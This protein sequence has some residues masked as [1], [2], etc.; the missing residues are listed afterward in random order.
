MKNS[1]STPLFSQYATQTSEQIFSALNTSLAGLSTQ[2]VHTRQ[3]EVGLNQIE[4]HSVSWHT[5]LR[6][7]FTSP[8]IYVF[9]I[10][11]AIYL[12]LGEYTNTIIV[13]SII[14]VNAILGFYQEYHAEAN[15][16]LLKQYLISSVTACRDGQENKVLNNL[17]VPGDI[18]I[19]YPGD[20]VPAD[21]RF[22]QAENLMVDESTLTGESS[23]VTKTAA[24][25]EQSP[26]NPFEADNIGFAGTTISSGKAIAV[27]FA[28]GANTTLGHIAYLTTETMS[29]S[30]LNKGTMRLA[31]F[32]FSLI[33]ITL[34]V[35]IVLNI[36]LKG[37]ELP[38]SELFIFSIALAITAIPEALPIVITFCLSKGASLL[39]QQKVIV[40]RLSAIEDLGSIEVLCTDK[41]GTLTENT[42][43]VVDTFS[44]NPRDTLFYAANM[45]TEQ[46]KKNGQLKGFD[47][48]LWQSLTPEEQQK[49]LAF[50][51]IKEIPFDPV[52]KKNIT[53]L[54]K[55][56]LSY[57]LARGSAEEIIKHITLT[58]E[59]VTHIQ[60]W[61]IDE[62]E[63]KGNRVIAIAKKESPSNT[64]SDNLVN[65]LHDL[66]FLGLI[67][68]ADPIKKTALIAV[69]KA[70]DLGL[71][72]KVLSGDSP[73]VCASVA[74]QLGLITTKDEVITGAEFEKKSPKERSHCAH[75]YT[76]FARVTPEQKYEIITYLQK[77]YSVGYLGDGINDA[78]ALKAA[79]VSMVVQDAAPI[80]R[81]TA[82]IILLKK[83]LLVIVSGI[84]E[85]R[86]IFINTLKYVTI[87]VTM[88][89]GNF[90]SL[91]TA[92][93]L[94]DYLPMLPFQLLMVNLISDFPMIAIA[95]DNVS[96]EA[97]KHSK[98][99]EIKDIAFLAIIMSGISSFYDFVI[100][101]I[102]RKSSPSTLQTSWFIASILTELACIFTLRKK[103]LFFKPSFPSLPLVS[104]AIIAGIIS[105][106]LPFTGL[107]QN[108][109]QL[110]PL[111]MHNLLIIGAVVTAYFITTELV[112]LFY[113][114]NGNNH[115]HKN[116]KSKSIEQK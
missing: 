23:L 69:K 34:I 55:D 6:R 72:L 82:D 95:T 21:C 66:T 85:G 116:I 110:I 25:Q 79:N 37:K 111:S 109:L 83:S 84:E 63:K 57:L 14:A 68:F 70:Q 87:S 108:I 11:I 43:T 67:S 36:L 39:A 75:S 80:A 86:K 78:P 24:P 16:Q 115:N 26:K 38:L 103:D 93:L 81:E 17:L 15:L 2:E 54:Q 88:T 10:I 73:Y 31:R 7:Q 4:K 64:I 1:K 61:I 89:F 29:E 104:L 40:K 3:K 12:V 74:L 41:T 28:T 32:I 113:Y 53:L 44:D 50:T 92:S 96:H 107:G 18:I 71:K 8:F 62:E 77:K 13:A 105:V 35:T 58:N 65:E 90:F 19:L 20:I 22:V 76:V 9:F 48:A 56:T 51:H 30:N 106:S 46:T 97:I 91:A 99:Y 101:A 59:Q 49:S 42:I 60:E 52:L 45:L 94:I 102:F 100:F 114:R 47:T 27:V 98:K 112:K 5:I 33:L